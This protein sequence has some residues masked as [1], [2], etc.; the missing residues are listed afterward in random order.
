MLL[1]L[2]SNAIKFTPFSGEVNITTRIIT[3]CEQLS[4]SDPLFE[5]IFKKSNGK[6]YLEVSVQDTG[7]GIKESDLPKLFKL[8]GFLEA[9]KK[10]NSKGIGLGLMISKKITKIFDGDIICRSEFGKGSTFTF[11]V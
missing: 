6:K 7:V 10:I 11:I 4:E 5:Q 9:S 8:F 1:N 2:V 3:D